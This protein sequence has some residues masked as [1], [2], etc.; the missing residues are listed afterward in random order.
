LDIA[1]SNV[2]AIAAQL[3]PRFN[4]AQCKMTAPSDR[5]VVNWQV[6]EGTMLIPMPSAAAGNPG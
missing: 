6:Q 5:Y 1:E 3:D 4:L 2:P